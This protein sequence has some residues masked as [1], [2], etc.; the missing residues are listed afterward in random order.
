MNKLGSILEIGWFKT[1]R[2]R[3]TRNKNVLTEIKTTCP[4]DRAEEIMRMQHSAEHILTN[5]QWSKQSKA[6]KKQIN[7]E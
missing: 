4:E 2:S 3:I 5:M 1:K 7:G 6:R